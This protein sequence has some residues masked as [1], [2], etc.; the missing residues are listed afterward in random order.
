VRDL[1]LFLAIDIPNSARRKIAE[2]QSFYKTLNLDA[3]WVKPSNMHL[4]LK[5]LGNTQPDLIPAI[6][7]RMAKIA[8]SS[9][10]FS[11]TFGKVGVFPNMSRPRVLWVGI[12]EAKGRLDSLKEKIELQMTC[13]G[14]PADYKKSVHHL[15]LGRIKSGKGKERLKKAVESAHP[16]NA[17]AFEVSS[18]QLI[19]SELTPQGSIYTV[20]EEFIFSGPIT[21]H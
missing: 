8:N 19:K 16:I 12:E 9:P 13:L 2:A 5:F 1:R 7:D 6:K 4:T 20:Q 11:V 17:S 14:F 15:T 3:T 21:R 10:P 18:I